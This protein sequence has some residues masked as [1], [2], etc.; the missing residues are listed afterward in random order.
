MNE[1]E[2]ETYEDIEDFLTGCAFFG[3]G[4]GGEADSGRV[5]LKEALDKGYRLTLMDPKEI[6]DDDIYC[7]VFFMGSIAPKSPE[8]LRNMEKEGYKDRKYSHVEMLVNA[9]N[10]LEKHLGKKIAGLYAAELGGSNSACCMAAAYQ[11]GIPV[12]DGDCSG[13]AVPE[14]IH[15]LPAIHGKGFLPAIFVDSWG[16]TSITTNAFNYSAMERIGKMLSIASYGELAEATSSMYGKDLKE[17]LVPY[18]LSQCLTVGRIMRKASER[19]DNPC[20]CGAKVAKGYFIGKGKIVKKE[21]EDKEGYYWGT[22]SVEGMDNLIGNNYRIWFKN[23][24][25]I[26]WKNDKPIA[27]SPDMIILLRYVDGK[28]L[29]NTKL[30][31]GEEIGMLIVPAREQFLT[32]D[33]ITVFGPRYFGFDFDY[34][35]F[36]PMV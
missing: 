35:Q 30:S 10:E 23:E 31:E 14:M 16:N 24:N 17:S 26:M 3:T 15:G 18:T 2:L 20:E 4:G 1:F 36:V 7:T 6:E 22:Y 33:A 28:P 27:T 5:A 32:D 25:H 11:K 13:R 19:G 8:T 34:K 9:V 12:L 29:S 21:T